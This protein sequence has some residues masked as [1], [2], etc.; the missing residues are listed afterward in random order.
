[1]EDL[2]FKEKLIE[3]I[4]RNIDANIVPNDEGSDEGIIYNMVQKAMFGDDQKYY[5]YSE[6]C[7]NFLKELFKKYGIDSYYTGE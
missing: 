3:W 1:M 2:E 7:E 6:E 5:D 4:V